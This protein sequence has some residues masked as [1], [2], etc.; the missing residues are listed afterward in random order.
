MSHYAVSDEFCKRHYVTDRRITLQHGDVLLMPVDELPSHP[1][2]QPQDD[3]ILARGEATGHAHVALGDGVAVLASHYGKRFLWAPH[4]ARIVHE[5][6]KEQLV[7]PGQYEIGIVR[8]YD[9]F[10]EEARTVVD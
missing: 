7:P 10:R 8:E 2:L 3:T 4:G 9:H 6:H 1:G 5:E